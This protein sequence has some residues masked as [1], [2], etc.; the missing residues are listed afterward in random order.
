MI[1]YGPPYI[2]QI[3][4][5]AGLKSERRHPV[6]Q[7]LRHIRWRRWILVTEIAGFPIAVTLLWLLLT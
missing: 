6:R 5:L 4:R 3:P 1:S 2:K 7:R